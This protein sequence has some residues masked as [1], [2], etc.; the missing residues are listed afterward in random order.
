MSN[1]VHILN[2]GPKLRL[3]VVPGWQPWVHTDDI[4][5]LTESLT[6]LT[7]TL[8]TIRWVILLSGP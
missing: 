3:L 6:L 4:H 7:P 5:A 2:A 8:L 1:A